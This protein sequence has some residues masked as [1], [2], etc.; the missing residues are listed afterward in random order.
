[1]GARVIDR[2]VD[3]TF[4]GM[5]NGIPHG[6]VNERQDKPSENE[7]LVIEALTFEQYRF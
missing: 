7:P 1:M 3:R 6:F 2:I 5:E 4:I